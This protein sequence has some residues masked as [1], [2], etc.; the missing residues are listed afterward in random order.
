MGSSRPPAGGGRG[1]DDVEEERK[2]RVRHRFRH[3]DCEVT[4]YTITF[5]KACSGKTKE[6]T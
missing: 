4:M 2:V 6:A 5:Q 1:A 3:A